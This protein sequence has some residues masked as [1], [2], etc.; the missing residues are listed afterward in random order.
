[1]W[2]PSAAWFPSNVNPVGLRVLYTSLTSNYEAACHHL[3]ERQQSC[4]SWPRSR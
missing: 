3:F 2:R 4:S 1:M